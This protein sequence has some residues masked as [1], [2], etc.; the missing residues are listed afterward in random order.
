MKWLN[1]VLCSGLM[2]AIA[3]SAF[4]NNCVPCGGCSDPCANASG[5]VVA[6][7]SGCGAVGV[8]MGSDVATRAAESICEPV[9]TYKVVMEPTY[10]TETRAVAGTEMR[11]ETR[12]RTKKVYTSVPVI[13]TR[14]RTK[15][16]NVAKTETKTVEYNV[17]VPVKSEKTVEVTESV[18]VWN[19]VSENYTV[20]V[21]T[22]V[23][24]AEEYTVQVATL[25]DEQF[26]YTVNVP[27]PVTEEKTRTVTIAVPVTKTREVER[28]V[29]VTTMTTVTNGP[30]PDTAENRAKYGQPLSRAGKRTA[31]RGN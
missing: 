30:V 4:A 25:R 3:S 1:Q 10:V 21:P 2:A 13:E 17:L 22:L 6:S 28:S 14:Y 27:H 29:P 7:G 31:A 19:E 11:T 15:T 16:V 20:K 9:T 18:P 12:Q 5:S 23:D 26:T 24:I 8:A